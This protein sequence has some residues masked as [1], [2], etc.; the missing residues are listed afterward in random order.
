MSPDW[1]ILLVSEPMIAKLGNPFGVAGTFNSNLFLFLY[2]FCCKIMFSGRCLGDAAGQ[3]HSS[4]S[5]T[6]SGAPQTVF[7]VLPPDAVWGTQL[8][9]LLR[10]QFWCVSTGAF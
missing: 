10:H 5:A 3:S 7:S 1:V 2:Y 6:Q 4:K 8:G 9:M